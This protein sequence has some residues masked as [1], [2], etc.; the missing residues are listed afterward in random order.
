MP[1]RR[2]TGETARRYA[3]FV[4]RSMDAIEDNDLPRLLSV[5]EEMLK[6]LPVKRKYHNP[7]WIGI[8]MMAVGRVLIKSAFTPFRKLGWT[9]IGVGGAQ[10]AGE[11]TR[12]AVE[13]AERIKNL[14]AEGVKTPPLSEYERTG[15]IGQP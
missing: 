15:G 3:R 11:V 9:M 10:T 7:W 6:E 8:P 5:A 4:D 14:R 2:I 1:A 12:W 13:M